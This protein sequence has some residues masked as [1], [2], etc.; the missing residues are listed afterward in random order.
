MPLTRHCF[1]TTQ[2]PLF[3]KGCPFSL[4]FHDTFV[5]PGFC[6][7]TRSARADNERI[8]CQVGFHIQSQFRIRAFKFETR[9][10]VQL[11]T[12]K[13]RSACEVSIF[14]SIAS[15]TLERRKFELLL[16]FIHKRCKYCHQTSRLFLKEKSC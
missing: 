10:V 14:G 7:E 6:K 2:Q 4:L 12:E 8:P 13:E 5:P 9:S 1:R 16:Q 11:D 15:N 3:L